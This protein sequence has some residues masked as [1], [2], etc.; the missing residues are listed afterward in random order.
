MLLL[1][2]TKRRSTRAGYA[3]GRAASEAFAT[4][5][6]LRVLPTFPG[7]IMDAAIHDLTGKNLDS[8]TI[9]LRINAVWDL[10]DYA[11]TRL[12][13]AALR[14][15][16][17][18]PELVQFSTVLNCNYKKRSQARQPVTL[19]TCRLM[20]RW[21]W[22]TRTKRGRF[23]RLRWTFLNCGML[24]IGAVNALVVK[25]ELGDALPDG[26]LAVNF[27]D[28]SDVAVVPDASGRPYIIINVDADKN[29]RAWNR[30]SAYIPDEVEALGALPV[31]WLLEYLR[32][33]Q[34]PSG[35]L[36]FAPPHA[37]KDGVFLK[38]ANATK[39]I[40]RAYSRARSMAG[41]PVDKEVVDA[42]GTH[43]GRKS[44]SQWLWDDGHC[45][46]LI[47]DAGGWFLK[48]DAVDLYFKTAADTIL[49]AVRRVGLK[50][51]A[52]VRGD[53]ED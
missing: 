50:A 12:G 5:M 24:R 36:L 1:S 35:S 43:S 3:T 17:R 45:R 22:D 28:G 9:R 40:K 27:V 10:Y 49:A 37:K 32:S 20:L 16:C 23:G 31:S 53:D 39:D 11:R 38:P 4:L 33:A 14:N 7:Q 42:L 46:R 41:L 21:G 6:D 8:S 47:A 51:A 26:H 44:L 34:P 2:Q 48:R 52:F 30:R 13:L 19:E 15:P 29:V 18:D 25:Y